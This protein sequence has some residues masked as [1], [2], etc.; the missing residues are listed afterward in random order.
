MSM[1]PF[2][3][4]EIPVPDPVPAVW[5]VTLEYLVLYPPAQR[6]N[7]GYIRV[8]PVS[9]TVPPEGV[10]SPLLGSLAL[11]GPA[12]PEPNTGR[13]RG[14]PRHSRDDR[15]SLEQWRAHQCLHR[16]LSF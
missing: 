1:V 11:G 3:A 6:L 4:S 10:S 8:L 13:P 15:S 9:V 16:F 2:S 5:M 14:R 7:S 12:A